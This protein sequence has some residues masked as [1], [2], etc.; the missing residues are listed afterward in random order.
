MPVLQAL[1]ALG[2]SGRN[3]EIN[4]KVIKSQGFGEDDFAVNYDSGPSMVPHKIVW[5]R[6][7][8]REAGLLKSEGGGV[9]ML[10][11]LG[12]EKLAA[13]DLAIRLAVKEAMKA[14]NLRRRGEKA[15]TKA[16]KLMPAED[17]EAE[18]EVSW[19]DLRLTKVQSID[20]AAF[21]CLCQ[22]LLRKNGFTQVEVTG[23]IRRRR[24]RW[25]GRRARQ[26]RFLPCSISE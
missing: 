18:T 6:S 9:W 24:D 19:S 16:T 8:L 11:N 22:M 25:E 12:R 4:N 13:G 23:K 5:A 17:S 20:P 1:D 26:S 15:A 3:E 10:T 21:E 2:G 14:Y 7:Y